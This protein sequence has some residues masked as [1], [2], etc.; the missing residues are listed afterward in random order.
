MIMKRLVYKFRLLTLFIFFI[1]LGI[2]AQEHAIIING[3][4]EDGF[5]KT[6]LP[7]AK[8]SVCRTDSTVIIDSVSIMPFYTMVNGEL[9]PLYAKYEVNVQTDAKAVFLH[10]QLKGYADEWYRINIEKSTNIDV[11]IQMRKVWDRTLDEVTVTATKIKMLHRGDT[12]IYDAKA[13][14]LP[15]GSMLDDLIR[16]M[17]GVTM[18][19]GGEIFVNGRKVDELMLGSQSFMRGNKKILLENLPYYTVKNIKVYDKQS[20]KSEA[21]GY[22]VE[23][24]KFVMDVNLKDEYRNG[25]IANVEA[26]AGTDERWLGRAFLLG[27][28]DHT[29]LT[30]FGNIN[31]VS[32]TRHIGQSDHWTPASMP[33]SMSTTRSAAAEY[34]YHTNEDKLKEKLN[35]DYTST[36]NS[37]DMHQRREQFLQGSTPLSVSSS[38]NK[39]GTRKFNLHNELTLQKPT[40]FVSE[41]DF[42]YLTRDASFQSAFDQWSDT[43]I[44]SKRSIGMSEGKAWGIRAGARGAININKDKHQHIDVN[45]IFSYDN[46]ES[47]SANRYDTQQFAS[48]SNIVVHNTN[49]VKN[50]NT[51]G[52]VILSYGTKIG[53]DISIGFSNQVWTQ[54]NITHDYLYHPDTLLL[55][56]QLDMLYAISDPR[57]S[58]DSRSYIVGNTARITMSKTSQHKMKIYGNMPPMTYTPWEFS[59]IIP[60]RHDKLEYERGALDTLTTQNTLFLNAAAEYRLLRNEGVHDLRI[61]A[62][63]DQWSTN[64]IDCLGWHDDSQPLIVRQG[65]PDL[66]SYATSKMSVNYYNNNGHGHQQSLHF[67]TSFNYDFRNIAQSVMYA[68]KTGVY[69]YKPMN[70]HGSYTFNNNFDFSRTLDSKHYWS[71]QTNADA[72]VHHSV[73]HAMLMDEI[74]SHENAVNTLSLHDG[75]Y[76]QYSKDKLNLRATV[77][78]RWRHSEGKMRDFTTLNAFDYHYGLSARYT[79][80][81][82]NTTLSADGN[83]FSRRGYGSSTL[84]TDDFVVNASISQPFLKGKL[85]ARIEAFDLFH[86]LSSTQYEVNAQGRTETWYR[87]LPHYVM[88]HLV[89]HWNKNPKKK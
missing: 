62:S 49:D 88:A 83:M 33:T 6:P 47:N 8:V 11:P 81:R 69:T 78:I 37:T 77:D 22:D 63:F 85:I 13:F 84:N 2:S 42:H 29:R 74:E 61:H 39:R 65:N 10:A 51:N 82:L 70:V 18:N 59:L 3:N 41:L 35:V 50:N 32:E 66:K 75:T 72:G 31:N 44:A 20:D 28:T 1:S 48:S 68:P 56:S 12:I 46:D 19:D 17:P 54:N 21:L 57:N 38:Q 25:Y 24:K 55:S 73:D 40:W 71:I 36:T 80:P 7:K 67:G 60:A 86:Q 4:V 23:P 64:L 14:N 30:L 34:Y 58:Y 87:S 5:L 52:A 79:L 16:Q 26:A 53:K 43:L 15:Q 45:A 89:Y 9:K 27:F 76:I